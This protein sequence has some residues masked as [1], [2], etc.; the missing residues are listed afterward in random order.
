[1]PSIYKCLKYAM[2]YLSWPYKNYYAYNFHRVRDKYHPKRLDDS[3]PRLAGRCH[4]HRDLSDNT[5]GFLV[6]FI[7]WKRKLKTPFFG[8]FGCIEYQKNL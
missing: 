6:T 8:V 5:L 2:V 4:C 7:T 3:S 1:M